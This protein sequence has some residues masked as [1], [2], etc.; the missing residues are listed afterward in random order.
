MEQETPLGDT[1]GLVVE[2]IRLQIIE[3]AQSLFLQYVALP[4]R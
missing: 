1:V 4:R 2:L 3:I